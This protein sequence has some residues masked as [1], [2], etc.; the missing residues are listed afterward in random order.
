MSDPD[1]VQ[2]VRDGFVEITVVKPSEIIR[3]ALEF[4]CELGG[5]KRF[6]E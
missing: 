2:R 5:G 3:I 4:P 1:P 6:A